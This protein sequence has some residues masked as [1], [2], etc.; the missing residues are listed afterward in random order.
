GSDGYTQSE[1]PGQR[2]PCT[3]SL[4]GKTEGGRGTRRHAAEDA[5]DG[6][7]LP[8]PQ[9]SHQNVTHHAQTGDQHHYPPDEPGIQRLQWSKCTVREEG[10]NNDAD[11]QELQDGVNLLFLNGFR[12][13][14]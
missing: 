4:V 6:N 8:R 14:V 10:Q 1:I 9:E 3:P 12:Q 2:F 13:P 11:D 7:S 5:R